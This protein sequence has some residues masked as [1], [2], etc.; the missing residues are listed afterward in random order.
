[1]ACN[2][3]PALAM[4]LKHRAAEHVPYSKQVVA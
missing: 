1:V 4:F 2:L 3:D